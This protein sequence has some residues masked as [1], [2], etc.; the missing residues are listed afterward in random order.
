MRLSRD[1]IDFA[2]ARL[3]AGESVA[4]VARTMGR[5]RQSLSRLKGTIDRGQAQRLEVNLITRVTENERAAFQAITRSKGLTVSEALRHLVKQANGHLALQADELAA[6]AAARRELSAIGSNL[7]Q[8]A[9]LGAIGKLSWNPSDAALVRKVASRVDD[10]S[11][12]LVLLF[13]ALGSHQAVTAE[14]GATVV[15][16]ASKPVKEKKT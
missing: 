12:G 7:N 6:I 9:R 14:E 8:L 3:K 11:E 16:G 2:E 10:L 13:A 15:A 4:A 1:E 5:S